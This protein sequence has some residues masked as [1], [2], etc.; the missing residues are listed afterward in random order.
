MTM[1]DPASRILLVEDDEV[2]AAALIQLAEP[3]A[4]VH[5]YSNAEAAL[6][7]AADTTWDL[8]IVDVGLPGMSGLD[9]VRAFKRAQPLVAT[10]VLTPHA[11]PD[12]AVEAIR[13]DADD[14]VTKPIDPA[15]FVER[16]RELMG[17]TAAR[18]GDSREVVLA[19]GAHP[20]DIEIGVGGILLRHV[21]RGD[22]VHLLTL[23]SG[24]RRRAVRADEQRRAARLIGARLIHRDLPA[25]AVAD[26]GAIAAIEAVIDEVR[27]DVVYTHS[28]RDAHPDHRDVHRATLAAARGVAR[29]YCYQSPSTTIDFRPTR[30]VAIDTFVDRKVEVIGAYGSQAKVRRY[31]AEDVLRATVR[32]WSRYGESTYAEPLEVVR[33]RAD[34]SGSP[35]AG[36][37][38]QAGARGARA[39][40]LTPAAG[41]ARPTLARGSSGPLPRVLSMTTREL[42]AIDKRVLWHPFTQQQGW[43]EE[44]P[45]IIERA[46][47]CTLF[48]TDGTPTS[49]ASSSLWCNVHGHRHPAIDARRARA[50]RARR[51]HDD[52]RPRAPA[53]DRARRAARRDRAA[54]PE[55][56]LLLRQRLDRGRGRAE[57][58]LPVL[59][60]P[61]PASATRFVALRNAYHG[62]TIGAVSVGGIDLF[63]ALLRAAAVRHAGR[64]SPATSSDMAALL[65]EHAG[66]V[67]AVIVEPLVQ[68]AAGILT[69]PD[70]YLRAVRE[71][72]DEHDVLLICDEVATGFGRTGTMF[73]CEQEG[74]APTSCASPRAS[75]AATCRSPR[76]SRPSAST[77]PSSASSPSCKTFFHGH[78]YTG[79]PLACAAALA[80][81][82]VFERE[83]T[84]AAPAAEDRAARAS[85]STSTSR[86]CASVREIRRRGVMVGIELEDFPLAARMGHQ[87]TLRRAPARRDRAPARR[88]R[89]ADAAA[90]DHRRRAAPARRDHRRRRSPRRRA[91]RR[92]P[93]CTPP[94]PP[95]AAHHA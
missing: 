83:D 79:N 92:G 89:R 37:D 42:A 62:D 49:T 28:L 67:A 5:W 88:R 60:P 77:R 81:L 14:V 84:L 91:A 31:L 58:G 47:G 39:R 59:A 18:I 12:G 51:A 95:P 71:L 54:R 90:V 57:D 93:R 10:L 85:C 43:T 61:R 72:C 45:L 24:E 94:R 55:P 66:E 50:A 16:I 46:E 3:Y 38:R 11:S 33:E 20:D 65:R 86:R 25:T 78:T 82:D 35:A 69:H 27:P 63:H 87:V 70:G 23:T 1:D 6:T 76:R 32:Y 73:A 44:E 64:P 30:F 80:T 19:I 2:V 17:L 34:A 40:P 15:A 52:A 53:G 41:A 21:A 36:R 7:I 26:G 68:G 4:E 13:T 74:V 22:G 9:F 48:D 75:P 8:V 29:V 56:R